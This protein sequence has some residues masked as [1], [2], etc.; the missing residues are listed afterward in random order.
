MLGRFLKLYMLNITQSITET[1]NLEHVPSWIAR[2]PP[3]PETLWELTIGT[4][5]QDT[6][7]HRD[8]VPSPCGTVPGRPPTKDFSGE[9]ERRHFKSFG[10]FS[11]LL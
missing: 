4:V 6:A 10:L 11:K 8:P 2:K 9:L 7:A 1:M 5:P 3:H